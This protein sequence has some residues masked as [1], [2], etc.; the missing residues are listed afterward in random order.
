MTLKVD[1]DLLNRGPSKNLQY[2]NS[3]G[4]PFVVFI[5]EEELKQNKTKLRN[6]KSGEEKLVAIQECLRIL[7]PGH[8]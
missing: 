3:L 5:G 1:L 7:K 6:M 2:A 8:A 4:I